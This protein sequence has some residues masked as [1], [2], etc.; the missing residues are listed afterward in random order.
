ML[1]ES[2]IQAICRQREG[3]LEDVPYAVLLY[4]LSRRARSV[5]LA[6]SR[7]PMVKEIIFEGGVPVHCRSNLAHET[8]SRFMQSVG[9]IDD[10]TANE[11]LAESCSRNVRFGDVLID[12]GLISAEKLRR[13]LQKNLA[14][15]LLD[16]FSWNQGR[17]R[18]SELP[19]EVDSSLRVNV[20]QLI[21]LGVTRFATQ[22]QIDP[23]IAPLIGQ[24]LTLHPDPFFSL[25]DTSLNPGQR[26]VL[27]ALG[28]RPHRIDELASVAGLEFEELTRLL[29]AF[30][31][32]GTVIPV[33]AAPKKHATPL[34]A[35]ATP[36]RRRATTPGVADNTQA[37]G[38]QP[39]PVVTQEQ[40]DELMELVLNY[41]RRDPFDLLHIDPDDFGR[42]THERFLSFAEKF[43]PWQ[44]PE[45]LRDDARRVFLAGARA[46]G[47]MTDPERRQA[48]IDRRRGPERAPAPSAADTFRIETDL[49]D[50]EVQYRKGKALIAD[51]NYREALEQ[52]AF[53]SDL[54]PQN[55][56]YRAELAYC[57]YLYNPQAAAPAAL[58]ELNKALRIDPSSGLVHYYRGEILRILG[59]HAEAEESLK[60]AIKPMTPDRRPIDALRAL[61]KEK[62]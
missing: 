25:N 23:S 14:R 19:P 4:A 61:Q 2:E 26:S 18:L 27:G 13:I 54:D 6:I 52:L 22:R 44:Y 1:G 50:P 7:P 21:V 30:V 36:P 59:R 49:L 46:Y 56:N 24:P 42:Q 20:A 35:P 43:S 29:Y 32:I 48:L 16:G 33:G 10:A 28:D 40:R 17:Y 8:L 41:R 39:Q 57:R 31:L 47:I 37:K 5:A 11:C 62:R 3:N 34:P 15:K 45:D 58:E 38:A 60:K 12:R 9:A 51:H 55:G 53:A